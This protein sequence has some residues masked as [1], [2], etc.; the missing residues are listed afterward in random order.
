MNTSSRWSRAWHTVHPGR[1]PLARR[2]DRIEAFT[3]LLAIAMVVLALPVAAAVASGVFAA[4]AEQAAAEQ[5]T[6]YR[7]EAT[8]LED[9][10]PIAIAGR[11]G[12]VH[13]TSP[14]E[15]T[16]VT[17][18][19]DSRVGEVQATRGSRAGAK[20]PVWLD[21][22]GNPV[23]VPFTVSDARL[24]GVGT[25]VGLW[26]AF[27]VIVLAGYGCVRVLLDRARSARWQEEWREFAS[28]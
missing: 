12:V 14:A 7:A 20:V 9:G 10:A 22:A 16:W 2:E 27:I 21:G 19:G 25:G 8:L 1:N 13:D 11:S 3:V 17:R 28:H 24:L 23:A 4:R 15:A 26:L 6:R 5:A 18:E